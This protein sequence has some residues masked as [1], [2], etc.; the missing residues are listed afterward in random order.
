MERDMTTLAQ[1]YL[2]HGRVPGDA[3]IQ[4][5]THDLLIKC[6]EPVQ[7]P[8]EPTKLQTKAEI[9]VF[10]EAPFL[11]VNDLIKNG[12]LDAHLVLDTACIPAQV[13]WVEYPDPLGELGRW[14]CLIA[15]KAIQGDSNTADSWHAMAFVTQT[16]NGEVCCFGLLGLPNLP[17]VHKPNLPGLPGHKTGQNDL[18]IGW[19]RDH[20]PIKDKPTKVVGGFQYSETSTLDEEDYDEIKFFVW[21]ILD[22]LFMIMTPR[23]CEVRHAEHSPKLQRS[24]QKQNKMPLVEYKKMLIRV[25]MGQP[26]YARHA[27]SPS[28]LVPGQPT[29]R[30]HRLHRVIGHFR[31]YRE[32]R[33]RP[34]CTFVPQHWRGDEKLGI[35]LKERH[36][37]MPE[38]GK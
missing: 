36:V 20:V 5:V 38:Q 6:L 17:L 22:A 9:F 3:H 33:E 1:T 30:H 26:R 12:S 37:A 28:E 29:G 34:Y 13:T 11:I 2:E 24:R 14:G 15:T 16:P 27:S 32:G 25:G 18:M 31:T 23:V 7:M 8:D 21:D 10:D 35:I 4:Q 19:W